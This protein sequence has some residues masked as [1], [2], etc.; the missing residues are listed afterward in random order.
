MPPVFCASAITCSVMVVL[1]DDSGPN[2]SITR[3]RGKPPTPNAASNEIDP[4]GIT[5]IGTI[6]SFDPSRMIEP[7]PNCFSICANAISIALP[8]SSAMEVAPYR[9][10]AYSCRVKI[11]LA[12]LYIQIEAKKR[13]I[14]IITVEIVPN[15]AEGSCGAGT[16]ASERNDVP[17]NPLAQQSKA[18]LARFHGLDHELEGS[19][20]RNVQIEAVHEEERVHS[21]KSNPLVA[22]HKSVIID[23]RLEQSRCLFAQV[24]VI[25]GLRTENRGFQS[26]LIAQPMRAAVLLDLV[27]MNGDDFSHRQINTLGHYLASFLYNSR[28]FSL[29][30]R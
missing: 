21:S 9:S 24:V 18:K 28:Y 8:R 4:V 10:A 2:T 27:M 17:G 14:K 29:E 26:A 13:R 12:G 11:N 6:A 23:Q 22:V 20:P 15:R 3:P 30:R 7:L 19:L 25:A 16:L 1:P 5:A